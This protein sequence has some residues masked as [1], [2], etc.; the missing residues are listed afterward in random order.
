MRPATPRRGAV[1][2]RLFAAAL[3]AACLAPLAAPRAQSA[4]VITTSF[5]P[6]AATDV[7]ARLLA[8]EFQPLLGTP[9]VVKNVTGAAGTI[10]TNEVVRARPDGTNI[11]LSPI[12]PIT[13]QPSF[14]RNAGYRTTD[15]VPICMTTRAPLVL[16]THERTGFRSLADVLARGRGAGGAALN[17]GSTGPGTTPHLSMASFARMAGIPMTHIAYR[18][19]GELTIALQSGDVQLYADLPNLVLKESGMRVLASLSPE[20]NEAF[21][22]APTMRELGFD[23]DFSIWLG[24]F[25]P[26]NTPPAIVA[27]YEAACERATKAPAVIQGHER[28]QMP[29][30]FRTARE[31]TAIVAADAERFR[32]IIEE[33]NLRAAE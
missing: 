12:G 8:A 3:A 21:P 28:L 16:M 18:G 15:L 23:L 7:I 32:R 22:D 5:G 14:M 9:F 11:L 10:A 25:A 29:V 19:P 30:M 6:A 26:P 2:R 27:R 13:I 31:F 24:L 4:N 20:R 17:Y 1:R 33:G